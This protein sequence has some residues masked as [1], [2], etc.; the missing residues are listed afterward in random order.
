MPPPSRM[1]SLSQSEL[2]TLQTF[3][4]AHVNLGFIQP[5]KLLHDAPIL[6][7]KKKDGSLWLCVNYHGLNKISKKDHYP[8]PLFTKI[9]LHHV[10]CLVWI[11]DGNKLKTTFQTHYGSFEWLVMPFRL[12]NAPATFQWFINDIFS[13]LFDVCIIIYLDNI[14]I[15]SEDMAQPK[16]TSKKS[17]DNVRKMSFLWPP[18]NINFIKKVLNTLASS[19]PPMDF[20]GTRQ[21][22]SHFVLAQTP[23]S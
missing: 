11:A 17:C 4:E 10:Y 1:Y 8:L 13:D 12:A 16:S 15:Y 21:S 23:K 7:V 14:L 6:F 22:S 5:S 2:E 3:I 20:V 9:D 18:W 19:F